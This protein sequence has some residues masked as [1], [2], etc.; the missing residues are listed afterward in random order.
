MKL[1]IF[2]RKSRIAPTRAVQCAIE[3]LEDRIAP[4]TLVS[5]TQVTFQDKNGDAAT[6]TISK[7]LFTAANVSKV[8]TFDSPFATGSSNGINSTGQQLETLKITKLGAAAKGIDITISATV[9]NNSAGLVDVGFIDSSGMDLGTVTVGGDLGRINAGDTTL[10]SPALTALQVQSMG[11]HG[12]TTQAAGGNLSSR[13]SGA[14]GSITVNGDLDG[15]AIGIGG[16]SKGLLGSLLVKGNLDGSFNGAT[17][18]FAGSVRT[19]GGITTTEVDGNIIGGAGLSSGVIG[20]AGK[21]GMVLVKGYVQGGGGSFSGAILSTRGINSVEVAGDLLG[22]GGDDSGQIGTASN[23]TTATVD[24]SVIGGGGILSGTILAS[25]DIGSVTITNGLVGGTG[26]DSGQVGSGRNVTSI[27]IGS[28]FSLN[29]NIRPLDGTFQGIEG[30]SGNSSGTILVAGNIGTVTIG[31]D[32]EGFFDDGLVRQP[33]NVIHKTSSG[34]GTGSGAISA[35]GTITTVN[36]T[37][38]VIHGGIFSGGAMG[39]VTIGSSVEYGSEIDGSGGIGSLSVNVPAQTGARPLEDVNLPPFSPGNGPGIVNSAILSDNGSIGSIN[40]GAS[41]G[42]YD[43]AIS[44]SNIAAN[45]GIGPVTAVA[46]N[47]SAVAISNSNFVAGTSIGA[48]TAWSDDGTAIDGSS[49][50]AGG[51]IG[52]I[53]ATSNS[54]SDEVVLADGIHASTFRAGGS[55]AGITAYAADT[56]DSDAFAIGSS[57]FDA[58]GNIGAI[59]G[60]G[61]FD[62]SV[63]IAGIDLGPNFSATGAGSFDNSAAASF[64][65]GSRSSGVP[66]HIGTITLTAAGEGGPDLIGQSTF[67]AGVHGAGGDK[68]FGTKD[69]NV[70]VGSSIGA[71]TAPGGLN[72]VFVESGSIG[73][74]NSGAMVATTYIATDPALT[75]GGIGPITVNADIDGA[76]QLLLLHGGAASIAHPLLAAATSDGISGSSFISNSGIGAIN[77]TMNGARNSGVNAGINT[78]TFTAGHAIGSITIIDNAYGPSGFNYGLNNI[79]FNAGIAGN[80]GVGDINVQLTDTDAD[81]N[82]VAINGVKVDATVCYCM[83]GNIGSI[84]A[85]NADTTTVATEG[86]SLPAGIVGSTFRA[87]GN[88]GNIGSSVDNGDVGAEAVGG[89]TF[90]AYGSIGDIN[91]YGAVLPDVTPSRFLAGYDIGSDMTF[92]NEVLTAKSV[93]LQGGQSIGNVTVTGYF[94]G[95]DIAASVNPG[96]GYVFGDSSFNASSSNDSHIGAGGTIGLV[97]LGTDVPVPDGTLFSSDHAT[98]HAIEAKTFMLFNGNSLPAVSASGISQDIPTVLYVDDGANDVRIT[99]LTQPT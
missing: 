6:V 72:T 90:S 13:I 22:G 96:A 91:V 94:E 98:Q 35:G 66:A 3:P 45:G 61:S 44:N 43:Y 8:F 73:A 4:A 33:A 30:S 47:R 63:F 93:A 21:L 55:I 48:I 87:Y 16:G 25:K 9:V 36:V 39:S 27:Q 97:L 28:V 56:V 53:T 76:T 20:T 82:S 80:G 15:A 41:G 84:T 52:A 1:S 7:G 74:T 29:P 78:S 70:P 17:A 40:A 38:S 24:S 89:S 99:N 71:I 79:T 46:T 32:I 10:T 11:A 88:I 60:T 42:L 19:Q 95:S 34:T 31:G 68:T 58:G 50:Q 14:V 37:E 83:A 23:L 51:G 85:D 81:G 65:F 59:N 75:A 26:A 62:S 2:S 86:T 57:G 64:G 77:V 67:L 12:L 92:G 5:P 69:D 18:A 49:F 54:T